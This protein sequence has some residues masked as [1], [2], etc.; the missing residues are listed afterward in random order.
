MQTYL[1]SK[2]VAIVTPGSA[3]MKRLREEARKQGKLVDATEEAD[4]FH[5]SY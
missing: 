1:W 3:P 2:V 4:P 5:H